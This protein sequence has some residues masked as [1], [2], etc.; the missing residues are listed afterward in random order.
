MNY[1]TDMIDRHVYTTYGVLE[2][3]STPVYMQLATITSPL[4]LLLLLSL[5]QQNNE[6][7]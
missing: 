4:L 1:D 6:Q 3:G 7:Q 5:S 2:L